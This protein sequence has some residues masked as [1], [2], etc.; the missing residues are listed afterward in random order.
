MN[1][2]K[3]ERLPDNSE[4][5]FMYSIFSPDTR[6]NIKEVCTVNG[7]STMAWVIFHSPEAAKAAAKKYD[8]SGVGRT[9]KK[10]YTTLTDESSIPEHA[11]SLLSAFLH[12]QKNMIE[13]RTIKITNLPENHTKKNLKQMFDSTIESFEEWDEYP[14]FEEMLQMWV[15]RPGVGL[16]QFP[17]SSYAVSAVYEW[18]GTYWKN[19]TITALCIPDEEFDTA[20]I[21]A[22]GSLDSTGKHVKLFINGIQPGTAA[23]QIRDLFSDFKLQDV[24]ITPGGKSFCSI[25][26]SQIDAGNLLDRYADGIHFHGRTLRVSVSEGKGK[27]KGKVGSFKTSKSVFPMT[28]L[29]VSNLPYEATNSEVRYLLEGFEL[30]KVIVR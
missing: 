20:I 15:L 17:S 27:G 28:D 10:A 5:P 26:L 30:S 4:S 24:N 1:V 7:G 18:S 16:V 8:N 11:T 23:Q 6:L 3:M 29:K 2:V 19:H 21:K 14:E 25:F 9:G 12:K 13:T 22:R